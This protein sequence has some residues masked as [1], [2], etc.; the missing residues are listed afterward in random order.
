MERH[1]LS[2]GFAHHVWATLRVI[3]ACAALTPEQ[4]ETAVPGTYGSI[5]ATLRHLVGADTWY[6]FRLS[7]ERF[8]PIDDETEQR[9]GLPELRSS[10]EANGPRWSEVLAAQPD[11][12]EVIAVRADD[13]SEYRA[14]KGVR[15]AQV[16]H[17]GTDHRSQVCTALTTF[18]VTPPEIGVWEFAEDAGRAV[19]VRAPA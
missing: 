5:I 4:L 9:M 13:G 2:D 11:P 10:M 8:E 14:P 6:L 19:E 1:V 3:E 18:G 17:H 7:G 16:L 15:L 12:D